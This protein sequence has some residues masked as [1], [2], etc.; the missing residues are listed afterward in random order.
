[1]ISIITKTLNIEN[2]YKPPVINSLNDM[3]I[4]KQNGH[5]I[6]LIV[7]HIDTIFDNLEYD[8]TISDYLGTY[9]SNLINLNNSV[10]ILEIVFN[11]HPLDKTELKLLLN[12]KDN[13]EDVTSILE[14]Q[15]LID[16]PYME[17][18]LGGIYDV[19]FDTDKNINNVK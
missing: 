18:D 5:K 9:I 7:E 17:I 4:T 6:E 8:I 12:I 3:L 10:S 16:L 14:Q 15:I 11:T 19:E 1:M 13:L 2:I